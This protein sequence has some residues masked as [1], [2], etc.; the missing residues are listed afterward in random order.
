MKLFTHTLTSTG[1]ALLLGENIITVAAA[2]FSA[3]IPDYIDGFRAKLGADFYKI[4]RK[5]SHLWVWYALFFFF[6]YKF[7]PYNLEQIIPKQAVEA[8][9]YCLRGITI[10]ISSHLFFDFFTPQGI[11]YGF[12]T[13]RTISLN[14]V[15]TGKLSE[16]IFFGLCSFSLGY[17]IYHDYEK[18]I[19]SLLDI[20]F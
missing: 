13:K 10:G 15:R 9:F 18:Y 3:N 11:P 4:H 20:P 8:L 1:I 17:I 12:N 7:F 16:Y 2:F 5:A 19:T 6:A 14:L